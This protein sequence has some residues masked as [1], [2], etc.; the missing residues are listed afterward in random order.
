METL[1]STQA[2]QSVQRTEQVK[3]QSENIKTYI[4]EVIREE[5][6]RPQVS[7]S[8]LKNVLNALNSMPIFR[9]SLSF[10]FSEEIG[11]L[12]VQIKDKK[13]DEIIRQYPDEDFINRILYYR[14]NIGLLFDKEV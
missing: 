7:K 3:R 14:D 5:T 13:S 10:G 9:D 8:D 12:M 2:F 1:K 11:Q 6:E 4:K